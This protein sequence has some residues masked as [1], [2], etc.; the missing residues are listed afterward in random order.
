MSLTIY[1]KL[2]HLHPGYSPILYIK[3]NQLWPDQKWSNA[4]A[5]NFLSVSIFQLSVS[6]HLIYRT[7]WTNARNVT[8]QKFTK[9]KQHIVNCETFDKRAAAAATRRGKIN[10]SANDR[11]SR[12]S[13]EH[14]LN[15]SHFQGHRSAWQSV[16]CS[17][18]LDEI[19]ATKTA[20]KDLEEEGIPLPHV[21]FL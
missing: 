21:N 7:F 10:I 16:E 8:F 12:D 2:F 15:F 13:L 4:E 14:I 6:V 17:C 9:E 18:E 5:L 1:S 3:V 20:L 11:R 19:R